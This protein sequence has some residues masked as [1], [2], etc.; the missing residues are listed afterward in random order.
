MI[1][2]IVQMKKDML[3]KGFFNFFDPEVYSEEN[4]KSI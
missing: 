2:F 3:H 4:I 1:I